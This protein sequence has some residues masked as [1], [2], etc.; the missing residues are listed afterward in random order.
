M[1]PSIS[2]LSFV[3]VPKARAGSINYARMLYQ[4]AIE[5]YLAVVWKGYQQHEHFRQ[6]SNDGGSIG[7]DHG[8]EFHPIQY[9]RRKNFIYREREVGVVHSPSSPEQKPTLLNLA[10][11]NQPEVVRRELHGFIIVIVSLAFIIILVLCCSHI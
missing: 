8:R 11:R 2:Y 1:K 6:Y 7:S 10:A 4:R 9:C 3:V 5:L